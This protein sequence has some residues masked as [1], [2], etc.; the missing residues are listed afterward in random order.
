MGPYEIRIR[1]EALEAAVEELKKELKF[2]K[3]KKDRKKST[4]SK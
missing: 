3:T 2:I 4:P 1:F